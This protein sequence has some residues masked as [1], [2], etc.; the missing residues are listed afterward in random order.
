MTK[1]VFVAVIVSFALIA[2]LIFH[3]Y[4]DGGNRQTDFSKANTA[5]TTITTQGNWDAGTLN[6]IDSTSSAGSIKKD[7]KTGGEIDLGA[8]YNEDST[9]LTAS[10]D[11]GKERMITHSGTI[12]DWPWYTSPPGDQWWLFDLGSTYYTNASS[13][14]VQCDGDGKE[15]P[16]PGY[17]RCND[18]APP[19][20]YMHLDVSANGIDWTTVQNRSVPIGVDVV[21]AAHTSIA[22]RYVRITSNYFGLDPTPDGDGYRPYFGIGVLKL[23]EP[24]VTSTH[25]TG[26]TQIDGGANF[27]SWD[28]FTPTQ[29]V[30]ANTSVTYRYRTSTDGATWTAWVAAIGSV[31]SRTGDD[32]NNPTLYRYLQVE[33]TLS[34]TD[35]ASTPTIDSYDIDYHTEVKPTAPSAE[36]ATTQ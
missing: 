34:N 7:V 3:F 30:P 26:A 2:G 10:F 24:S 15:M 23:W 13:L 8:I 32:D 1:K 36:T 5:S 17:I 25:T 20:S 31:T 12:T 35:G 4:L 6:N 21:P 22:T 16:Y 33:A 28:G 14:G 19:G 27:W 9:R 11:T 18:P 29:T